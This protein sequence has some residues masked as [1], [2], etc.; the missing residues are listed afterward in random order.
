VFMEKLRQ[1]T[2]FDWLGGL[3]EK[4]TLG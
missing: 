4:E 2:S 3:Q 1:L